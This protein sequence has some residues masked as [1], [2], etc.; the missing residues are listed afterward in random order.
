MQGDDVETD[1][2]DDWKKFD[3]KLLKAIDSL[4]RSVQ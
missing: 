3:I 4:G 1:N 2:M